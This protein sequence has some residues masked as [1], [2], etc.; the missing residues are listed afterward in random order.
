M[1][2]PNE[3]MEGKEGAHSWRKLS[4]WVGVHG[5]CILTFQE[6]EITGSASGWSLEHS[7]INH[8]KCAT[9]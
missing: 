4:V 5:S 2:M 3:C 1:P 8:H 9:K 6:R 7:Q